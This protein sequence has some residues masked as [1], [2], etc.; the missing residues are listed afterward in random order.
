MRIALLGAG[1][2]GA[3]AAVELTAAG[4]EVRWWARHEETLAAYRARGG[5][6]HQGLLGDG[7]A[8]PTLL[9]T[10]LEGAIAEADVAVVALPTTAHGAIARSLAAA[11][12]PAAK[13]IV[14]NP[15]HTGGALEFVHAWRS[16]ADGRR[17]A[18]E[19]RGAAPPV[20]ELST[21]TYVARLLEPGSVTVSGRARTV[22]V[23]A[24]PGG[25][26]AVTAARALFP[27]ASSVPDVIAS[28]LSNVNLVL[29][30]PGAILAAA[31]VEATGG[32]FTFYVEAMTPGV[33][34]VLEALDAERVAVARAFG[35]ELPNLIEEMRAIG[36]VEPD[37]PPGTPFAAAI[38]AAD[39]N[40]FI[41]APGS[42]DHRYYRE[43]FGHCVLAFAEI[44]TI[45]GVPV[46]VAG[47]LLAIAERLIGGDLR[48]RGRTAEA[49]G[50]AG[51]TKAEL[52]LIVRGH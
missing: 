49:M 25:E 32:D 11:R 5:V 8:A 13:P 47:S 50:I 26:T 29:H 19:G 40:R 18:A 44:A 35:H 45:A 14:L 37:T 52:E 42:F 23:A 10:S 27:A 48:E 16:A 28:G 22:R 46:P 51:L 36:T 15:G 2:G 17:S 20:A 4:H 3:A 33:G 43:D 30:P 31:W 38:A 9:T 6:R 24:L 34:R 21:L 7:L 39:A 41:K 1:A 12:W